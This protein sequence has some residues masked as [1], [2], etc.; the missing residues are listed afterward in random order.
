[1]F[2]PDRLGIVL[3]TCTVALAQAGSS[4]AQFTSLPVSY[5]PNIDARLRTIMVAGD[6]AVARKNTSDFRPLAGRLVLNLGPV[7]ITAGAGVLYGSDEDNE[8]TLGG[9]IGYDVY[10]SSPRKPTVTV[11]GAVGH[12]RIG[13][14]TGAIDRWDLPIGA[15]ISW[16]LP[17]LDIN[18][19]PWLAPRAHIRFVDTDIPDDGYDTDFGAGASAGFK[20]THAIGPG[21]HVATDGLWINDPSGGG[22]H[23][24]WVLSAGLHVKLAFP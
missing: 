9:A 17:A 21:L 13:E 8:F 2:V 10:A 12:V 1:L 24:E 3:L 19:E 4:A 15:A 18:I 16:Y 6:I 7:S 20:L 5:E 22:R 11:Q 23:I 14:G